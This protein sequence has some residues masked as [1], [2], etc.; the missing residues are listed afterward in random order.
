MS[1]IG[2]REHCPIDYLKEKKV[3]QH[4]DMEYIGA[5]SVV[6]KEQTLTDCYIDIY[7]KHINHTAETDCL[8]TVWHLF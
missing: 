7:S 8:L 3:P 6:W 4:I 5:L 1:S 2:Q